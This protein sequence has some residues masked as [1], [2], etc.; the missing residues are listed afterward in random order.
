M[1]QNLR[2]QMRATLAAMDPEVAAAKSRRACKSL[3]A[4]P[5]FRE[6]G[7]VMVYLGIPNEVDATAIVMAAWKADKRTLAPKVTWEHKHMVALEFHSL[8]TGLVDT[9]QG[10]REPADGEPWP[11]EMIDLIVVPALAYDRQGNRLGRGGGFYD[12]FLAASGG[13]AVTCGL[14]FSEQV[15]AE[16][17][18]GAH[19]HPVSLLVSDAEVLRFDA[20]NRPG[21]PAGSADLQE[22]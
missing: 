4:L 13:R 5:E 19:D 7:V 12:R 20:K 18:T 17:P 6:A 16:V 3:I 10:L 15:V 1:K 22:T 9:P 11:A 2:R 21:R 8:D 14:A